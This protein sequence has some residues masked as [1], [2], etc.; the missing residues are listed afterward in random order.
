MNNYTDNRTDNRTDN[1]TSINALVARLLTG[2]MD[3]EEVRALQEKMD[4]DP[5]L[6][7]KVEA[8]MDEDDFSSRYNIYKGIDAEAAKQRFMADHPSRQQQSVGRRLWLHRIAACAAVI[9]IAAGGWL[10]YHRMGRTS[11]ETVLTAEMSQAMEKMNRS[12]ASGATLVIKGCNPVSVSDAGKA[13]DRIRQMEDALENRQDGSGAVEGQLVTEKDKEFWMKLDDGTY[14][15]LNYNTRLTYPNHFVGSERRVKLEGEAYFAIARDAQNRP[16]IVETAQGD[17]H[18][19]GTEF[20]VNT[21]ARKG[22]TEVVLVKGKVTVSR[23][24]GKEYLLQ[25]GEMATLQDGRTTPD[26]EK[27]DLSL[28]TSWNTGN[29]YFDGCTLKELMGVLSRWYGKQICYAEDDIQEIRFT[30][31]I[32]KYEPMAP[33]LSA[34][35]HITGLKISSDDEAIHI[36]RN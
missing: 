27:V 2:D 35:E 14:V 9:V 32:D 33:T 1:Y 34:I 31:S 30:G 25:P 24:H 10:A 11:T 4:A 3:E 36:R 12:G 15:H 8:L 21:V 20:N 28:Y 6:K 26:I 13:A 5:S 23:A 29:F 22:I 16:F 19:Y 7:Q 18:D 17:V